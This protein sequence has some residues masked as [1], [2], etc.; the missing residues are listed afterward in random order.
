MA[1]I[2][3]FFKS[4]E[5]KDFFSRTQVFNLNNIVEKQEITMPKRKR[6]GADIESRLAQLESDLFLAFKEAKDF[7]R[8]R[9]AKKLGANKASQDKKLRL[10]KEAEA[11]EVC[12]CGTRVPV[13]PTH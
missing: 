5:D 13:D 12:I 4:I 9:Q 1:P 6:E 7:E 3:F 11:L 2:F 8:K 10:A